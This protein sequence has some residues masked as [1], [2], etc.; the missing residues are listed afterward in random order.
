MKRW[1]IVVFL[2]IG[3]GGAAWVL[4]FRSGPRNVPTRI[5]TIPLERDIQ[6]LDP[7]KESD[8]VNGHFAWQ[9]YEGLAGLNAK[10]EVVPLLADSWQSQDGGRKWV[11]KLRAGVEFHPFGQGPPHNVSANDVVYSYERI[12]KGFGS[13]VFQG[14]IEGFD[15]YI[16]GQSAGISGIK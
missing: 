7:A 12:A 2:L 5:V 9:I 14:V 15:A 16:K 3:A 11:F 4:W 10:N 13:F 8:P 1:V 6:T